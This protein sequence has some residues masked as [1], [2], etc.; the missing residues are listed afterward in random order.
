MKKYFISLTS[1]FFTINLFLFIMVYVFYA[2]N[3]IKVFADQTNTVT[4]SSVSATASNP[5]YIS[6]AGK[7][8]ITISGTAP[9]GSYVTVTLTDTAKP[10][11]TITSTETV[12]NGVTPYNITLDGTLATPKPLVDGL[13]TVSVYARASSTATVGTTTVIRLIQQTIPPTIYIIGDNPFYCLFRNTCVDLGA[14][15]FD[16]FGNKLTVT[17]V[18]GVRPSIEGNYAIRYGAVD[19]AGNEAPTA[20]RIVS[21]S[22]NTSSL[23]TTTTDMTNIPNPT[24]IIISTSS[25]IL[26]KESIIQIESKSPE[27]VIVPSISTTTPTDTMIIKI[28]GVLSTIKRQLIKGTR[29]SDVKLLQTLLSHD[30]SVY[31][32]GLTTGYFG[33]IT[34][35]AVQRFQEKYGIASIGKAGYGEVGPKT[36]AK[37]VEIYGE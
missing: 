35:K 1:I 22:R 34:Q 33:S 11:N 6:S 25:P 2:L 27:L 3:P 23:S 9:I 5:G 19:F 36:R 37:L 28:S 16:S 31:P 18:N 14:V 10:N 20:M 7:T 21:V 29:G 30:V 13:I 26:E 15:A 17:T 8:N 12:S 32:E 4:I 24:S